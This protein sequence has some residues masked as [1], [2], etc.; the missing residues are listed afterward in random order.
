MRACLLL[1]VACGSMPAP[2][3]A[4]R[5]AGGDAGPDAGGDAPGSLGTLIYSDGE[6]ERITRLD[7]ATGDSSVVWDEPWLLHDLAV[8]PDGATLMALH[9]RSEF[10]DQAVIGPLDASSSP[11]AVG[12]PGVLGRP[13]WS[14]GGWAAWDDHDPWEIPR[15]V[16]V[17]RPED[18]AARTIFPARRVLFEAPGGRIVYHE[19]PYGPMAPGCRGA[20][21]AERADG[22]SRTIVAPDVDAPIE[23]ALAGVSH[24]GGRLIGRAYVG[25]ELHLFVWASSE[26]RDYGAVS[27]VIDVHGDESGDEVLVTRD[28]AAFAIRIPEGTERAIADPF[29]SGHYTARGAVVYCAEDEVRVFDGAMRSF[30]PVDHCAVSLSRD[31]T[32]AAIHPT[33][34]TISIVEIATGEIRYT[35][36]AV[37]SAY[38]ALIA[39]DRT[40][41]GAIIDDGMNIVHAS[42]ARESRVLMPR[43]SPLL[44]RPSPYVYVP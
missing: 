18:D 42:W 23:T 10:Y 34:D 25:E 7:V 40:A 44:V 39:F 41:T 12:E 14:S 5:D 15:I 36:L 16:Y 31:G 26:A 17:M 30:G 38:P 4:A 8:S 13:R 21:I 29:D 2:P 3:D 11:R 9:E 1:L 22:S 43:E 28:G 27:S 35:T 37:P 24:D 6:T 33:A 19:C 20:I 32:L